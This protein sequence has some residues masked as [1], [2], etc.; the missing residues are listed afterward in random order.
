[1]KS[2]KVFAVLPTLLTLGNAACG[3][4]AITFAAKIGPANFE[5]NELLIAACLIFL[6]MVFDALEG[7]PLKNS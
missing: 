7:S 2:P 6:G 3:F 1:M 5:G 4:G